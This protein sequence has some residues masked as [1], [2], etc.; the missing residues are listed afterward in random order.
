ML[1]SPIELSSS[2]LLL[3]G[4]TVTLIGKRFFFSVVDA[5]IWTIDRQSIARSLQILE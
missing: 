3:A 5:G 1:I 4:P 2:E